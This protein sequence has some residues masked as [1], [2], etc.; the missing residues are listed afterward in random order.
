MNQYGCDS[1][2]DLGI[3]RLVPLTAGILPGDSLTYSAPDPRAG[4]PGQITVL[5][6]DLGLFPRRGESLRRVADWAVLAAG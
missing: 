2:P 6:A 4:D 1:N 3:P 5:E